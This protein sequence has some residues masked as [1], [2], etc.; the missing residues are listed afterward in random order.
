MRSVVLGLTTALAL[1][2]PA[3][4]AVAC[5]PGH[6]D[7]DAVGRA[8]A[9]PPLA[10]KRLVRGLD[11][12]WDVRVLGRGVLL[13]TQRDR[14]TLGV[15]DHGRRHRVRF[16]SGSVWVSGETGLMGLEVDPR[17][18]TNRRIYTCQGGT[19]ASGH[20]VRVIAWRLN[21]DLTRATKVRRLVGGLPATSG[22]HG[23]CRLLVDDAGS[24]LVGTGDAA[25]ATNPQDKRSLGGKTLRLDRFT[26]RP[27]PDNPFAGARSRAQRY[28]HTYGHRNVQGLSQRADGT[29]WSIEQGTDRDDEVNRLV[30]GGNY[31][32]DPGPG[33]DESVPM[34]DQ[35][36]PGRQI[37]AVWSSGYP[38]LATSGGGFVGGR[39]LGAYDGT[40]AVA[41]LKAERVLFLTLSADGALQRVHVPA[42]L[43]R[44]GRIRTVVDGPGPTFYVTTD[45]GGGTDVILRVRPR[46]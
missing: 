3:A 39:G 14:A 34:T 24:L 19:T 16:P 35:S 28:V 6:H 10:V 22:R 27:W 31:G 21:T 32:Y 11:H 45:N 36:L 26:G 20:D 42:E 9:Y 29:L 38:T 44:Y 13:Y 17:F 41:A 1:A 12:P 37:E 43:R 18:A 2:L 8:A 40:L 46:R 5:T 4:P 15:W 25:T 33:Y 7:R 30:N 23:G